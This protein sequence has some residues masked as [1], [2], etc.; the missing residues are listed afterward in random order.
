VKSWEWT[1]INLGDLR[2]GLFSV[3]KFSCKFILDLVRLTQIKQLSV[4][5]CFHANCHQ[6]HL[7]HIIDSIW[8]KL[9]RADSSQILPFHHH[10]LMMP[11]GFFYHDSS[12]IQEGVYWLVTLEICLVWLSSERL[13]TLVKYSVLLFTNDD[14][15]RVRKMKRKSHLIINSTLDTTSWF[16]IL[17]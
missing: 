4:L 9:I 7:N 14:T 11:G 13:L 12:C 1:P 15:T 6:I 3:R 8:G 2:L 10:S 16:T 5:V 17:V